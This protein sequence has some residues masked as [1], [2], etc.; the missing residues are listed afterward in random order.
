MANH[1]RACDQSRPRNERKLGA[2]K[3]KVGSP[4][5]LKNR[6]ESPHPTLYIFTEAQ[7]P[8]G[9]SLS[10]LVP[11]IRPGLGHQGKPGAL[12]AWNMSCL[13]SWMKMCFERTS[14]R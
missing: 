5:W 13:P 1:P 8:T 7:E 12:S 3:K 14:I 9:L 2:G 10:S 11:T 6:M 4:I